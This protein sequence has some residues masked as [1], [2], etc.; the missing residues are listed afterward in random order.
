MQIAN[1]FSML[2]AHILFKNIKILS[3]FDNFYT[4]KVGRQY[5]TILLN[6]N[7]LFFN[8]ILYHV[9]SFFNFLLEKYNLHDSVLLSKFNSPS[10]LHVYEMRV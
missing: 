5:H 7:D 10:K 2:H 8:L 9:F 3:I 1:K 4:M 6:D